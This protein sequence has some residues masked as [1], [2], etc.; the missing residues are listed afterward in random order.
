[1]DSDR[2]RNRVEEVDA[3]ELRHEERRRRLLGSAGFVIAIRENFRGQRP[4]LCGQCLLQKEAQRLTCDDE[5][6]LS[7]KSESFRVSRH[8]SRFWIVRW[9][10][11]TWE[12]R[13]RNLMR[14]MLLLFVLLFVSP[15]LA[16]DGVLEISQACAM[17]TGCFVGDL[18]GFPV[19][20]TQSGSYRLT[21]NLEIDSNGLNGIEIASGDVTLDLSGF[22]V[23]GPSIASLATGIKATGDGVVVRNGGVSGFLNGITLLDKSSVEKIVVGTT[24][25]QAGALDYGIR[26]GKMSM[27]KDSSVYLPGGGSGTGVFAEEGSIVLNNRI[28]AGRGP[29]VSGTVF[30]NNW[31]LTNGDNLIA[32]QKSLIIGTNTQEAGFSLSADSSYISNIFDFNTGSNDGGVDAGN[33]KCWQTDDSDFWNF[34]WGF[35]LGQCP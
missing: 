1:V 22:S 15:A 4:R 32:D 31:V 12:T 29:M 16:T 27:V 17:Q 7:C 26:V 24:E 3:P 23:N 6:V 11:W 33:N 2:P 5:I 9:I 21:S 13:K 35:F 8:Y 14:K 28:R 10:V 30:R 25:S 18:P 20:I 34:P 19:S